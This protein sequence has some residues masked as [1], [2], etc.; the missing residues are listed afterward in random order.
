[1]AVNLQHLLH[2]YYSYVKFVAKTAMKGQ[3]Y[4]F[5]R[6]KNAAPKTPQKCVRKNEI[7]RPKSSVYVLYRGVE[8]AAKYLDFRF[9][10]LK[11]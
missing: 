6:K 9:I 11:G 5:L 3:R 8:G 1:M 7:T 4:A 10:K 2:F